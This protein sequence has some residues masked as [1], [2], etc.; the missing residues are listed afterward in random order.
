[1]VTE[2]R[3]SSALEIV[4]TTFAL[5]VLGAWFVAMCLYGPFLA[6]VGPDCDADRGLAC[7]VAGGWLMISLPAVSTLIALIVAL[8][9]F[10]YRGWGRAGVIGAAYLVP[11]LGLAIAIQMAGGAF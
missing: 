9:G 11:P 6:L 8:F 4:L 5:I 1:M 2:R 10:R 3:R 7:T